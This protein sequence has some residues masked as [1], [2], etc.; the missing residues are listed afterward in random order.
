[1][2][3]SDNTQAQPQ[4]RRPRF[5]VGPLVAGCCFA[6][7]YGITHR[8]VTLQS[9]AEEPVPEPFAPAVFPG[10]PIDNLR[11]RHGGSAADLQ[12][13]LNRLEREKAAKRKAEQEAR[14]RAEQAAR[15]EEE[16]QAAG[17][18]LP[19]ADPQDWT[20][21]TTLVQPAREP[22]IAPMPMEPAQPDPAPLLDSESA[23][24]GTVA[25]PASLES[26]LLAPFEDPLVVP[27]PVAPPPPQP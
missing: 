13:D 3:D 23:Q 2:D 27:G 7:G 1:M 21:P 25:E 6:L 22:D 4:E 18:A 20:A 14:E 10:D 16:L 11:A 17:T 8:V 9:N 15:A 12:V 24:G 5:W 26:P 19:S